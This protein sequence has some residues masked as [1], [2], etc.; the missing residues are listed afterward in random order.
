[1]LVMVWPEGRVSGE[2]IYLD[3][4]AMSDLEWN[5]AKLHPEKSVTI[6]NTEGEGVIK[7][8]WLT[9]NGPSQREGK[10]SGS[11]IGSLKLRIFWDGSETPAVEAPVCDF[12]NQPFGPQAVNNVFCMSDGKLD[13]CCLYLPMPFKKSARIE[14]HNNGKKACV[15]WY[16]YCVVNKK[17]PANVLYLH[18]Q[19]NT[20]E[21]KDIASPVP[22]LREV[23]G[24]GRYLG[25]HFSVEVPNVTED[26]LW[27]RSRI[28]FWIDQEGKDSQPSP[29]YYALD[30]FIG[31]GWWNV[32]KDRQPFEFPYFGRHHISHK[33][34]DTELSVAFYRY[35]IQDPLWFK[36]DISI[37]LTTRKAPCSW[38][39]L[40][41]YYLDT[42]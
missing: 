10:P 27:Y 16:E 29:V 11:L 2:P 35:F 22:V 21:V 9:T 23:R 41:Y 39:T 1:M 17:L 13:T 28:N 40:S 30:D 15:L 36:K 37:F 14:V 19:L 34:N 7:R 42:P 38:R 18:A 12:F 25:T 6:L 24:R 4:E 5:R 33:E 32:E 26:W 8:I 31:S 20:T 3:Q